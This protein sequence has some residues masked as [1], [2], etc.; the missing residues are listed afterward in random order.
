MQDFTKLRVWQHAHR[1]RIDIHTLVRAFPPEERYALASQLRRAAASISDNIAESCGYRGG[2][3]SARFIQISFG[4]CN[5]TLN[6]LI[7]ARDLGYLNAEQFTERAA[8]LGP[9]RGMLYRLLT[10][11]REKE[12]RA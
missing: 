9:I 6:H 5:E 12:L 10:R 7:V 3:D 11:M 8:Q 4:S 2:L 1:F